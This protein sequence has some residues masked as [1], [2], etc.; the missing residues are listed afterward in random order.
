MNVSTGPRRAAAAA[1]V[2]VAALSLGAVPAHAD[3][4]QPNGDSTVVRTPQ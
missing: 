3:G 2:L 4:P 1:V